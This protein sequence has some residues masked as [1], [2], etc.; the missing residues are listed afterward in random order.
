[1]KEKE[2]E[3]EKPLMGGG[4]EIRSYGGEMEQRIKKEVEEEEEDKEN[5]GNEAI[6]P[7]EESI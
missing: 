4:W 3:E 1:M 7:E 2:E 6:S 5:R